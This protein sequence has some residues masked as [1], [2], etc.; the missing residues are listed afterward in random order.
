MIINNNFRTRNTNQKLKIVEYLK[1]VKTHP[2][3]EEVY[4]QVSKDLPAITLATVYRNLNQLADQGKILK[5]KI[6]HEYHFDADTSLHQHLACNKCDKVLDLFQKEI[7]EQAIKKA[8]SL[9]FK[10]DYV[11]IIFHGSCKDCNGE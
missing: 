10:P 6:H 9:G 11:D 3:A 7:S 1:R 5:F 2:T 4:K 8:I